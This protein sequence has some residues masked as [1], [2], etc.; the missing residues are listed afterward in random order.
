MHHMNPRMDL[1][2]ENVSK[3]DK[4]KLYC[5]CLGKSFESPMPLC[6]LK[7]IYHIVI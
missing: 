1:Y 7:V 4:V 5:I 2:P 6:Y 3:I